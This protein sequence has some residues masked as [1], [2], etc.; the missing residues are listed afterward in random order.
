VNV[1]VAAHIT[2]AAS[3]GPRYD[4]FMSET[5]RASIKNGI[6]LC[7]TCAK[8]VDSD[9]LRYSRDTLLRWKVEAEREAHRQIGK[10]S[11]ARTSSLANAER[12]IKNYLK[13]RD[14]MQ[15]DL[16]KGA[17][18]Y[19]DEY[20][21]PKKQVRRP[22][23]KFR[24]SEVIIHRL[25][26]DCYPKFDDGPGISSWFKV[27]L[28]DFYENGLVVI[29][30]IKRGIIADGQYWATIEHGAVFDTSQFTVIKVWQLG[31][32]PFR[33][34]RH[35]DPKGDQNYPLPHLYCAFDNNGMP[36]E[37]FAYAVVGNEVEYD[38]PLDPDKRLELT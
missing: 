3:G 18:E 8:L 33:N 14:T 38:W 31:K 27:E 16:L 9:E 22:Y 1:G 19:A 20:R 11:A 37:E 13:L 21:D 7:Q 24:R 23:E 26:D 17:K 6:W 15:G 12:R 29:L 28:F 30:G 36:Y 32:I 4:T 5:E 34:I 25:G 35:Y 2:A 10:T